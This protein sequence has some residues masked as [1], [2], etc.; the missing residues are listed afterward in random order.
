MA[1]EAEKGTEQEMFVAD[2]ETAL[3]DETIAFYAWLDEQ[4]PVEPPDAG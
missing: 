1:E 2:E 3:S 4:A